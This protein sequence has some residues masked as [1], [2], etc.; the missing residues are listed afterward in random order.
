MLKNYT[1]DRLL[2]IAKKLAIHEM[3]K[4]KKQELSK[5]LDVDASS[6]SRIL[7]GAYSSD[8]TVKACGDVYE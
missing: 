5:I 6:V 7:Q 2:R 1:P 3:K 4:L 8:Y